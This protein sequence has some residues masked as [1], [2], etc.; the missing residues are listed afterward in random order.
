MRTIWA[1]IH[2]ILLKLPGFFAWIWFWGRRA[3]YQG[4]IID[5]KAQA[6]GEFARSLSN[7]LKPL[8]V[9]EIPGRCPQGDPA[10]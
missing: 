9:E 3:E 2:L 1:L 8:F 7:P 4:R 5:P 6:L 10:V